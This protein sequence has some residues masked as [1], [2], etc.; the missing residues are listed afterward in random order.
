MTQR[1]S[2]LPFSVIPW[3]TDFLLPLKDMA[4]RATGGRP[5]RAVIVFPNSR[6]RRYMEELY[7]REGRP[8]RLPRMVT[9]DELRELC[10]A[11][12]VRTPPLRRAEMPDMIALLRRCVT[13]VARSRPS[14]SPL[15]DLDRP[16][17]MARFLPWGM[18][19]AE[20]LEECANQMA[21]I[22]PLEAV[23]GVL[24]FA[25]ALLAVWLLYSAVAVR[26]L[27]RQSLVERIKTVE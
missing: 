16:G 17:G 19:L 26:Y 6:P 25:A 11:A 22:R 2:R 23:D 24:P 27:H 12:W 7:R 8:M 14:D 15:R 20:L 21:E 18:R 13:R 9:V 1:G 10:R 3:D 4:D 5:G